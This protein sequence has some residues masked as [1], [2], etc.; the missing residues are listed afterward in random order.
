MPPVLKAREP[1]DTVMCTDPELNLVNRNN[2]RYMFI[3][4]SKNV[5]N[6]RVCIWLL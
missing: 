2:T 4:I 3:D 5:E 1:C 6:Y